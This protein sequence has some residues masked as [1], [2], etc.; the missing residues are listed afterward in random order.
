MIARISVLAAIATIGGC[1]SITYSYSPS[2]SAQSL[3]ANCEVRIVAT[4]PGPGYQELGVL[5]PDAGFC[6]DSAPEF[7][8]I[9]A[10]QVC[11]AGGSVVLTQISGFGCYIRGVVFSELRHPDQ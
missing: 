4:P 2:T 8:E 10:A 3:P 11:G 7:R 6:I 5:D 9:V 1:A